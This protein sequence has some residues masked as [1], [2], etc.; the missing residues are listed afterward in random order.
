MFLKQSILVP[1]H[2]SHRCQTEGQK[3][4][5]NRKIKI[6]V[7]VLQTTEKRFA[8]KAKASGSGVG[9]FSIRHFLMVILLHLHLHI[10]L[11]VL[12]TS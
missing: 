4:L 12:P 5:M 10:K 1:A 3:S 11:D 7:F 9:A 6:I 8:F 2:G